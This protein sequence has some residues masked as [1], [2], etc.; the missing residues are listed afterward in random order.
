MIDN[1]PS[2][3]SE[4][5]AKAA[6][7][8]IEISYIAQPQAG[9]AS[10]RNTALEAAIESGANAV[11]FIDD[12]ER[13][14]PRWLIELWNAHL[15]N[16]DAVISGPAKTVLPAGADEW[17]KR[18]GL[19]DRPEHATGALLPHCPTCNVLIPLGRIGDIRFDSRFDSTGGED[20]DFF[21]RLVASG[22]QIRYCAEAIVFEDWDSSRANSSFLRT[23][24]FR[25]SALYALVQIESR[26]ARGI[27]R[28][29]AGSCWNALNAALLVVAGLVRRDRA[30][31]ERGSVALRNSLGKASVLLGRR[32]VAK[33]DWN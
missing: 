7:A 29:A 16:P 11:A 13:S 4:A 3:E 8:Q 6:S 5:V 30:L 19:A 18:S 17:I 2:I 15:A 10:A 14:D 25:K 9:I 33:P 27:I 24:A 23:L 31:R 12:D 1:P 22:V 20:T 32:P 26:G 21:T 28:V